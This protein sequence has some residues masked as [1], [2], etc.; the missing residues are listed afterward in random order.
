MAV[1]IYRG[2]FPNMGLTMLRA[3][4]LNGTSTV[5]GRTDLVG[6]SVLAYFSQTL[7]WSS[8]AWYLCIFLATSKEYGGTQKGSGILCA[9]GH[10]G[11][12]G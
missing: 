7:H 12:L 6:A 3:H 8:T 11:I 9:Q 1:I 5:I 2:L 4:T 10:K